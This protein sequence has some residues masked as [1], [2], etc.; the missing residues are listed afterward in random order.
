MSDF[1]T[2]QLQQESRQTTAGYACPV[3]SESFQS[4]QDLWQHGRKLHWERLRVSD[5]RNEREVRKRFRDEAHVYARRRRN[6]K[7]DLHSADTITPRSA[8]VDLGST[9][10]GWKSH[11]EPQGHAKTHDHTFQLPPTSHQSRQALAED[12][13]L[14]NPPPDLTGVFIPAPFP[15]PSIE[16]NPGSVPKASFPGGNSSRPNPIGPNEEGLG[17]PGAAKFNHRHVRAFYENVGSVNPGFGIAPNQG[18]QSLKPKDRAATHDDV[19]VGLKHGQDVR[20]DPSIKSPARSVSVKGR[21]VESRDRSSIVGQRERSPEEAEPEM[22]LQPETKPISHEQLVVEVKSIYQGL[23]MVEAKCNEV[24]EKQLNAAKDKS[25]AKRTKLNDDQWRALI[26]LHKTL[27]HEHHDFFLAS[28]HPSASPNLSKLAAKYGMPARMW[29]HG[30][31]SFLEVLRHR[32]PASL[33]HMLAFIYIA[34]SMVALL[35]ETVP[36]FEGTWIECLGDLSRY[37]MAIEDDDPRDREVWAGV[38]RFWYSKAADS[39]PKVGRLYHHLAILAR[40]YSLQQL[41]YYTLSLT[42]IKQFANACESILTIFEPILEGKESSYYRPNSLETLFI[43]CHGILFTRK[44]IKGFYEAF[45]RIQEELLDAYI[46]KVTSRF[47]E[48]GVF[49]AVANLAALLEYGGIRREEPP[50][51]FFRIAFDEIDEAKKKEAEAKKEAKLQEA[52]ANN[53]ELSEAEFDSESDSPPSRPIQITLSSL[54]KSEILNSTHHI[55][56]ASIMTFTTFSI[57]LQRI[58]DKNVFPMIHVMLVF[59]WTFARV[60]KAMAHI[61]GEVPWVELCSFLNTLAK[62]ETMTTKVWASA[63]PK[64]DLGKGNDLVRPLPED[65]V[66]RGQ[67]YA[68]W[69]FPK[70]WFSNAIADDNERSFSLE[71][72]SLMVCRIERI[73]WLALD[74]WISYDR[75]NKVFKVTKYGSDTLKKAK[76]SHNFVINE[77]DVQK[78]SAMLDVSSEYEQLSSSGNQ[79]PASEESLNQAIPEPMRSEDT[80]RRVSEFDD[81]DAKETVPES[82]VTNVHR[83]EKPLVVQQQRRQSNV[84]QTPYK[85]NSPVTSKKSSFGSDIQPKILSDYSGVDSDEVLI[86]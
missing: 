65:F 23:I 61:E 68:K 31:H 84:P 83:K 49:M 33:D 73:L 16:R 21:T 36:A 40:P 81:M 20:V 27:L 3:C 80:R 57:A 66:I 50:R 11:L 29:R 48:Q 56:H 58:A 24:D 79:F 85:P 39:S 53:Q 69:Y 19:P 67:T 47:R 32:L 43:K 10:S 2:Q 86:S 30:I 62:P 28:Q 54:S 6:A 42:S 4:E 15:G 76:E 78:D 59:L 45:F 34:Y 55:H 70:R 9:P 7:G 60:G 41:S 38:A 35:Y 12:P 13:N 14:S 74:R 52:K 5:V 37:R 1:S 22:L 44:S 71:L 77:L 64:P 82:P 17:A 46:G 25:S 18:T 51:A 26:A 72:P 8:S 63:F 75:E